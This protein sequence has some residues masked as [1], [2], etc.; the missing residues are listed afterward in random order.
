M[1]NTVTLVGRLTKDPELRRLSNED[2]TATTSFSLAVQNPAKDADGNYTT[3]FIDCVA[4]R[5]IAETIV[6]YT[7]KGSRLA[8]EGRLQQRKYTNKDGHN[9]NVVEVVINNIQLCD[10]KEALPIEEKKEE[11]PVSLVNDDDL[12]F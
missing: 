9:V 5:G 8:I 7:K 10:A 6:K 11:S 4:W 12:P 1:I 3:S 2:A